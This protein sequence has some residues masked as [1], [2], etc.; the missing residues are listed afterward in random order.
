MISCV[1]LSISLILRAV[2]CPVM[3]IRRVV[4]LFPSLFVFILVVRVEGQPQ[5]PYTW[6]GT[7]EPHTVSYFYY[8]L[9]RLSLTLLWCS[10]SHIWM[11]Q[12][13]AHGVHVLW[14]Q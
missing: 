3:D 10:L 13:L 4:D 1:L 2:V 5:A 6:D 7:S 14:L 11:M 12:T 8:Y 9:I